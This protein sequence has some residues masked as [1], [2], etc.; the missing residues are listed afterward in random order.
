MD[1]HIIAFIIVTIINSFSPIFYKGYKDY[2]ITNMTISPICMFIFSI[3]L[4]T[5]KSYY[6]KNY[7]LIDKLLEIFKFDNVI[8]S[9]LSMI[10][11]MTMQYSITLLPLLI[12]IP[13]RKLTII[14]MV[15]FDKLINKQ[16]ISNYTY[17]SILGILIGNFIMGYENMFKDTKG[18]NFNKTFIF[19]LISLFIAIS[20]VGYVVNEFAKIAKTSKDPELV[21][22][23]ESGGASI[24]MI[25][26][27]SILAYFKKINIPSF[28]IIL[29]MILGCLILFD[30]LI[31]L[32]Y[33]AY[34]SLNITLSM[35]LTEI[36]VL[37]GCT[38]A[39]IYYKEKLTKL[40]MLGLIVVIISS[41]V[42]GIY[43]KN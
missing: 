9:F 22:G 39:V 27:F 29:Q 1:T 41:I 38:T 30:A 23:I 28:G 6:D 43:T 35:I 42:G 7:I 5:I 18:I 19:A 37:L 4:I 16:A 20:M 14:S 31:L 10:R 36:G 40:K 2:F 21:M 32:K 13:L 17:L 26:L 24:A 25:I 33:Y 8:L 12:I 15:Y 11:F 3:L 34:E